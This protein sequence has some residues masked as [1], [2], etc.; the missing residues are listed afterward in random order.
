MIA[1]KVP[2]SSKPLPHESFRS[3]SSSGNEPYLDGPK[4]A[5]CVPMRNTQASS[6]YRFDVHK[7]AITSVIIASS[8]TFTPSIT[9]LLLNRSA[10]NPPVMEKRMKGSENRAPMDSP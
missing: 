4:K 1:M 3:G 7:P 8:K 9:D 6:R 2:S 5:L 10:R